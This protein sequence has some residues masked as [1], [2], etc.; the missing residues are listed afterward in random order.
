MA[1]IR[2]RAIKPNTSDFGLTG[3]QLEKVIK[4]DIANGFIPFHIHGSLGT[5]NSV[6][7]DRL[8]ELSDV[9]KRYN[10]WI[11]VDA[12]YGG[13]PMI[14]PEFRH[15][16]KGIENL[17][18][19][20]LNLHKWPFCSSSMS[21]LWSRNGNA[22]QNTF[23]VHPVYLVSE[24]SDLPAFRHWGIQ[25]SRRSLCLKVW[26]VMRIYGLEGMQKQIRQVCL[27]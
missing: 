17:D 18:S 5:T 3:A 6:A 27:K 15:L 16:G 4:K 1:M 20:N 13:C 7:I 10:C 19:I 26:F 9:A 23:A 22:V 2:L 24:N 21:M 14:C 25:L 12:A 8:E 11:H